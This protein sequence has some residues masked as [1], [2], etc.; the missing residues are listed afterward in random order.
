MGLFS[1]KKVISVSAV[2]L[3]L[4]EAPK[5]P[6]VVTVAGAVYRRED[7]TSAILNMIHSN[8]AARIPGVHAYA[9]DHY[10]L[11]LPQ[12]KALNYSNIN[13][14]RIDEVL[15]SALGGSPP[16]KAVGAAYMTISPTIAAYP[17]LY[18]V[19][20]YDRMTNLIAVPPVDLVWVQP[21]EPGSIDVASANK[22][23]RLKS[24]AVALD[25]VSLDITYGLFLEQPVINYD[26]FSY[27]GVIS[28]QYVEEPYSYIENISLPEA[29]TITWGEEYLVAFYNE[30]AGDGVTPI[31]GDKPW[32]YRVSSNVYPDL[33]STEVP[34]ALDYFPVIPLRYNNKDLM[35]TAYESTP[36]YTTS[37]ELARR[38]NLDLDA[39]SGKLNSN[40]SIADID[41]AYVMYGINVRTEVPA[42]LKYLHKFFEQ[43]YETQYTDQLE[44]LSK[45][46]T[47]L[48]GLSA[49]NSL[50]AGTETGTFEENGLSVFLDYDYITSTTGFGV[51][52]NNRTGNIEKELV[53]YTENVSQG[54]YQAVIPQVKGAMLL[55]LQ[56]APNV[57]HTIGV[58]GLEHRNL[59]Y[60]GKSEYT[61]M[62][63][64]MRNPDENNLVIPLQFQLV[65]ALTLQ[66]R[67]ELYSDAMLMIINAY[68]V[69]KLKWYQSSWFKV[70]LVIVAVILIVISFI[71]GQA[72]VAA[73]VAK[74]YAAI[75][76]VTIVLAHIVGISMIVSAAAKYLVNQF[77][78]KWGVIGTVILMV[79]A[80]V[81]SQG[82]SLLGS[83][84]AF[85][86]VTAQTCLQMSAALI[87]ATN[88]FL[89][90]AGQE[91][92]ND[93]VD[94]QADLSE[95]YEELKTAEDLLNN[96][97][98]VNPLLYIK[99][100]RFKIVPN[101][102]PD[103][104]YSRCLELPAYTMFTIHGQVA[105]YCTQLL[106]LPELPAINTYLET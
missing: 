20:Q 62:L 64:V 104:F 50:L 75:T 52:G 14:D 56:V 87:G 106:K 88:E 99:P 48:Y 24:V 5:K 45:V 66:L 11:G 105:N 34:T 19:R 10:T 16:L 1:S 103:R 60:K 63:D 55:K 29:P 58:Y 80:A 54:L 59:I 84:E 7:V 35:G 85:A 70:I 4:V 61:S 42:S 78:A 68:Q 101:E 30:L 76:A 13:L 21:P 46:G 25:G 79:V 77:G 33:R 8:P 91:I 15:L 65:Q 96:S 12:G 36:L 44:Y 94:F 49:V 95:R 72:W 18:N 23:I 43:L 9:R 37:R 98:D 90:K 74:G 28:M 86:L 81:L 69:T 41:H 102:S 38:M 39:L 51:I 93:Y 22:E 53:E 31:S 73:L 40:E 17:H 83:L 97:N 26:D 67:T 71:Y 89:I 3:P 92:V 47:P 82:R 32:L 2:T 6:Y 27:G 57:V 100:A